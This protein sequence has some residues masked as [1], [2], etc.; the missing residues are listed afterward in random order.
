MAKIQRKETVVSAPPITGPTQYPIVKSRNNM[1]CCQL[2]SSRDRE[3]DMIIRTT[4][5]HMR[6]EYTACPTKLKSRTAI[7]PA[8]PIPAIPRP[9]S[10]VDMF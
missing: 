1:V 8:E 4:W 10:I 9:T 7:M 5:V 6:G 3:S 2:L